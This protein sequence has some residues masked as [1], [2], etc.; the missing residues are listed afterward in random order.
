MP[1]IA[2]LRALALVLLQTRSMN[3]LVAFPDT[4]G[5]LRSLASQ[6]HRFC[7]VCGSSN[8]M[9]LGLDCSVG[10]D[11]SV[12][13][14]FQGHAALEGYP[15]VLH[16][17]LVATLLDGAMTQCLF[18]RG[19]Q[20]VTAALEIRYLHEVIASERLTVRAWLESPQHGL[21]LVAAE[22]Q[23]SGRTKARAKGKF[24][25]RSKQGCSPA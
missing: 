15:G 20:A 17:G 6:A 23:Q 12:T 2:D 22:I 5:S 13:A 14:T 19:V 21:F 4:Q 10:S 1:E 9:G 18:A 24:L 7:F 25:P 3:T 8:P 16:G 11:G